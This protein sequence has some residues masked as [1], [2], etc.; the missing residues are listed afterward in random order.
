VSLLA[1]ISPRFTKRLPGFRN[2]SYTER[3][4]LLNLPY[5]EQ[6]RLYTVSQKKLCK[7]VIV[8]TSSKFHQFW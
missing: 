1:S 5:I 7:I 6:R 3:L 4:R 8:R 2:F